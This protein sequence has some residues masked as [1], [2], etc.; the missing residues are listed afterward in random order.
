MDKI[1]SP[2]EL[3]LIEKTNVANNGDMV[4]ALIGTD[5]CTLKEY[6]NI[7]YTIYLIPHSSNPV[8]KTQEYD[9]NEVPCHIIGVVE[10]I[11]KGAIIEE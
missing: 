11:L 1:Y 9:I 3:L 2:N 10:N 8:H 4:V 7:D 5:E 6:E